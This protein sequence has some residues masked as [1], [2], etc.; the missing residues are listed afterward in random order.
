MPQRT[1]TIESV[2]MA[3]ALVKEMQADGLELGESY[4][5][6][7]RQALS[8]VIQGQMVRSGR[9][10]ARQP[11]WPGHC[12][13]GATGSYPRQLLSAL[14]GHRAQRAPHPALLPERGC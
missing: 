9:S 2:A 12:A 7:G 14:G 3:F 6:L 5:P 13:T 11:R 1:A 10:L 4:R 8:E